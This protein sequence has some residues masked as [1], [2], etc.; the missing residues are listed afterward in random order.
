MAID[1]EDYLPGEAPAGHKLTHQDGGGDEISVA[2]LSGTTAKLA[3]HILLPT[4]HQDAP[5][6]I[7][8]HRLAA[9]AHHAKYT[10]GEAVTAMGALGDG[11]PLNHDKAEEWGATEHTAIGDAAPHHVKYTDGEAVTAMG[12]LGDGNPLN[13]DKAEEWGATEH[14]A[15]GD[16][17]PHHVKYTDGEA[18]TAMGALGDG[19]P[20]NHVKAAEWGAAEHT[21]IGDAA[22]HHVKYTDGEAVAALVTAN[23]VF[24]SLFNATSFLYA[25]ANNTPEVKTPAQVMAILS[26]QAAAAFDLN[27]QNL[28]NIG[29]VILATGKYIKGLA[30]IIGDMSLQNMLMNG[31]FEET[32]G[33]NAYYWTSGAGYSTEVA[34]GDDSNNYLEITRNGVNIGSYSYNPD[35]TSRYFEVNEGEVYEFGASF[36]SDGT[37]TYIMGILATDKDKANG[38]WSTVIGTDAAWTKKSDTYTVA[39]GK[40]FLQVYV[41]AHV[42]DGWAA[43]DNVYLKRVDELAWTWTS[44]SDRTKIDLA[45]I[46]GIEYGADDSLKT[47]Y[48]LLG[49]PN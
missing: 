38:A 47:G 17:A 28:T 3:A 19:N 4:V 33:T 48:K 46:Y 22:P 9:A 41:G 1:H 29:N 44:A 27:A 34:G 2:G 26:G 6:L 24:K 12:A 30:Q 43:F 49:I 8:A 20:L 40:K 39:S 14:T 23:A 13:H 7:E 25:T 16:A 36:K 37:C 42:S 15:I 45:K 21:A 18:V 11:N 10:N 35:G 31:G 5:A 32:D